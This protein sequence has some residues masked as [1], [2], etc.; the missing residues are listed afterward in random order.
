M[1][2]MKSYSGILQLQNNKGLKHRAES[3]TAGMRR[4]LIRD[5][6]G[7]DQW[8]LHRQ[9]NLDMMV[10]LHNGFAQKDLYKREKRNRCPGERYRDTIDKGTV[11]GAS[12]IEQDHRS[13]TGCRVKKRDH[14][15]KRNCKP[16]VDQ[17]YVTVTFQYGSRKQ[18]RRDGKAAEPGDDIQVRG[19]VPQGTVPAGIAGA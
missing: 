2:T 9:Q 16:Q 19:S 18:I 13:N 12:H 6:G 8:E 10:V 3:T 15:K 7:T 1:L 17:R 11:T 4:V 5:K 14:C